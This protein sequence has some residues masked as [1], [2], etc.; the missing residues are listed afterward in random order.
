[1][2]PSRNLFT[3]VG[4]ISKLLPGLGLSLRCVRYLAALESDVVANKRMLVYHS[5]DLRAVVA[6]NV[7]VSWF[8][9]GEDFV[10]AGV[11]TAKTDF[12]VTREGWLGSCCLASFCS[13]VECYS[14]RR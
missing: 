9:I 1:M 2:L 10:G 13:V 8:R 5:L 11:A 6:K 12:M 14:F 7:E 3:P 4:F